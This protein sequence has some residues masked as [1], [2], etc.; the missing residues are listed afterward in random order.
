MEIVIWVAAIAAAL[1]G[2]DRLFLWMERKGW[3][4]WRKKKPGSAGSG[5]LLGPDVFDPG[6]R[7]LE[8]AREEHVI[9]EED[10]GDDDGRRK[11]AD[12]VS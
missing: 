5:F 1:F 10:D 4:Y 12:R 6:K 9:A 7:Y 8:E 11:G 3:V 2:L